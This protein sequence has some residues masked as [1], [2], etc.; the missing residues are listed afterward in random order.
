LMLRHM[1]ASG[2]LGA[3]SSRQYKRKCC[4]GSRPEEPAGETATIAKFAAANGK[5]RSGLT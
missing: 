2:I 4:A 5:E 1:K 3:V